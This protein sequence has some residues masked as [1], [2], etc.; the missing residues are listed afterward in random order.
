M[1]QVGVLSA[2][3]FNRYDPF[4][5]YYVSFLLVFQNMSRVSNQQVKQ[6]KKIRQ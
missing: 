5:C 2:G 6:V 1:N 4:F 3:S